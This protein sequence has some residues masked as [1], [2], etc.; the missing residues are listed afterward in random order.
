[1]ADVLTISQRSFNMSQIR[2]K[3]TSPE[4]TVRS[5]VHR[6]GFRYALHRSDLPGHPDIVLVRHKKIIFVHGCFW[7]MHHCRYGKV[8]PATNQKFW[9]DKRQG[10]VE[11]DKRNLRKL[12]N[13]G[14]KVLVIWE[15]QTKRPEKLINKISK[16]L[17]E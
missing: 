12:R 13:L 5:L 10:N 6:M 2:S 1:M 4:I 7:H 16:F 17:K 14:W 8:K 3:N 15:C 11:R 9:Q